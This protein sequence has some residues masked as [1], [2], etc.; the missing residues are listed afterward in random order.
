[1]GDHY[2]P[3]GTVPQQLPV[4]LVARHERGP[5]LVAEL[6]P[7]RTLEDAREA[8]R[9]AGYTLLSE[10]EGGLGLTTA[11]WDGRLAHLLVVSP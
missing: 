8:A 9:Q 10:E 1:M 4:L 11:E 6:E 3:L 5:W 2:A 7:V